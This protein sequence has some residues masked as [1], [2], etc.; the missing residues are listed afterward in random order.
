MIRVT[1][2]SPTKRQKQGRMTPAAR[3]DAAV[4]YLTVSPWIIGFLLFTVIPMALSLY[5][6]FTRW[7]VVQAPTWIGLDN[8]VQMFTKDPDFYQS[9]KVT[10]IYTVTSVPLQIII[11]LL[12]AIL[13][14][15][16]TYAVGFFRTSFYIPSI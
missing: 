1:A 7:N 11:A 8:Y 2:A 3:R 15:E 16:A 13:L 5:L 4:F 12:L 6:S 9:L 10:I 14:N